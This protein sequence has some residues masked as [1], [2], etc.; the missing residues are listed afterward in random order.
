MSNA[1]VNRDRLWA[2]LMALAAV[3]DPDRPWTR[4]SFTP[5]FLEGRAWLARRFQDAGLAVRIDAAGNLIGRREGRVAGAKA[6]LIGSH[7]DSVPSGGRFDG[8]AGVLAGLEVAR[9][10]FDRGVVLDHAVE[11]IDFLAEEPSD[12][13]LSCVGSRG[14]AGALGP[15][16]LAMTGPGGET[17]G[18]AIARVGGAP[19]RLAEAVRDDVAAYLELHIEQGTVLE[20]Q[21]LDAGIVTAIVGITRVEIVFQGEAAHAGTAGMRHRRDAAVAASAAVLAVRDVATA[22][23]DRGEGYVVATTGIV[24]VSPG[25]A[26]VVP[27]EARIVI[28]ARAETRALCDLLLAG[29]AA[30]AKAIAAETGVTLAR[31]AVLSRNDPSACDPGLRKTLADSAA[32]LGCTTTVMASGAGHDAAF[33]SRIA[34]SAMLF[35]PCREGRSHCPEEWSEPDEV[36]AGAAVLFEAVCRIDRDPPRREETR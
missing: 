36:A 13:G 25:A 4:R 16:E 34:P 3:T 30:Q 22:L 29:I 21:A 31:F 12:Y 15:A 6:I 2:D 19:E 14:M 5:R 10:L 33:V 8:P 23:L 9:A 7:S 35:I 24:T 32:A 27:G 1:P 26:N 28:D 20:S 18:A 17:L 11:V